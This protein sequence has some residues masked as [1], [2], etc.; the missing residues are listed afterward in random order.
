MHYYVAWL[1]VI[2]TFH[3]IS[4]FAPNEETTLSPKVNFQRINVFFYTLNKT[5]HTMDEEA[6]KVLFH[7]TIIQQVLR[8]N[9]SK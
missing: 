7:I 5:L 1:S 2:F 8:Q 9:K 3:Q 4:Y 6:Y